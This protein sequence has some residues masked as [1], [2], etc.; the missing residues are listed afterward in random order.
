MAPMLGNLLASHTTPRKRVD[1]ENLFALPCF[2]RSGD[3]D[4]FTILFLY[5]FDRTRSCFLE[6]AL[7][8]TRRVAEYAGELTCGSQLRCIPRHLASIW[9]TILLFLSILHTRYFV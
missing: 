7:S 6:E 9:C 4:G 8:S 2:V 3:S 5:L 1:T